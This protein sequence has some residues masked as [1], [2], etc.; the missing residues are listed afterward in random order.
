MVPESTAYRH[1]RCSGRATVGFAD[2][3]VLRIAETVL[4]VALMRKRSAGMQETDAFKLSF[5]PPKYYRE[6][7]RV[8]LQ[9][10]KN[11]VC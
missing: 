7:K 3:A 6:T 2:A 4:S 9:I 8:F 5:G 11:R 10:L 1:H